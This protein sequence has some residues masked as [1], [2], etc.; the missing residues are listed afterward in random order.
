[1]VHY[2]A[3]IA[4]AYRRFCRRR[5]PA[6]RLAQL[7][8]AFGATVKYLVYVGLS[9]LFSGLI[10]SGQPLALPRG[11]PFNFLREPHKKTL[12]QWVETLRV[13]ATELGKQPNRFL[14]ELPEVCDEQGYLDRVLFSWIA[15]NR[16]AVN[17]TRGNIAFTS[18][19]C[20]PLLR[21]AR[22]RLER[23]F[24]EIQFL[25]S[26]PLGF[27]T[28]GKPL[29]DAPGLR[30]YRV[31]SCMGARVAS[32]R[33][34]YPME[35]AQEFRVGM[36]FLVAPDESALLYLWP[37]LLQRESDALQRPSLYVF[38]ELECDARHLSQVVTAAID[39]EDLWRPQLR[40]GGAASLEWL[41]EELRNLPARRP[42]PADNPLGLAQ[43]IGE[44][45]AGGLTGET[46]GKRAKKPLHL[47]RPY[48]RG[49]FG[50]IYEARDHEGR[51]VAVKVVETDEESESYHRFKREFEKL[52]SA[53]REHRGII[54]CYHSGDD[55]FGRQFYQWYSMEFAA[56]GDLHDQLSERRALLRGAVAWDHQACREEIIA[57]FRAVADAAA[58]LHDLGIIHRDLKPANV[59]LVEGE[60]GSEPRLS[61]FGLVKDL[62]RIP[63]GNTIGP[64]STQ[65]GLLGSRHY[66]APEQ[67]RGDSVDKTA[68]VYSLGVI[69]AELP[70]GELPTANLFVAAG[71]PFE[72]DEKLGRL[73]E[74]LRDLIV[75]CTDVEPSRRPPHAHA[76][77]HEFN[78]AVRRCPSLPKD[79][80]DRDSAGGAGDDAR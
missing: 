77:L 9:D 24:Q 68:D 23:F 74:P 56:G 49:G 44:W 7:F 29:D 76:V 28:G 11:Q 39:H 80:N 18:E 43:G 45:L 4:I 65:G 20:P 66:M 78:L 17:H 46:L 22:P 62:E 35:T 40:P 67:E 34:A 47:I 6:D 13:T 37:F 16:N 57:T 48:A 64:G 61:D 1:V 10:Q 42:L 51:Q 63:T 55:T 12:G 73:P 59:L 26:Y 38:E 58:H 21:E 8:D 31:H 60:E 54:Q 14:R 32:A 53:G 3:P 79:G 25:R 15:Q 70:L 71:S 50:V 36:P 30:R 72:K 5:E 75:R 33:E 27:L 41:A 19:K 52:R 2:P 69:L